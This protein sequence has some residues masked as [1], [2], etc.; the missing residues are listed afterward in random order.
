MWMANVDDV[1]NSN[2]V[3]FISQLTRRRPV[4]AEAAIDETDV[5]FASSSGMAFHIPRLLTPLPAVI[6][7]ILSPHR[8]RL[9]DRTSDTIVVHEGSLYEQTTVADR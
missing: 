7:L 6:S 5:I 3:T 8:Q 9:A 1:L 4:F 2:E